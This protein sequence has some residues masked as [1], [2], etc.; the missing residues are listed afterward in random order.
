MPANPPVIHPDA[1]FTLE[2]A[3]EALGLAETTLP[4]EAR[5]GRLRVS[6]RAGKILILGAWLLEWVRTGEATRRKKTRV[7]AGNG[8]AATN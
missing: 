7:G 1:V 6:K 3:R 8:A 4:R 5:L 2:T